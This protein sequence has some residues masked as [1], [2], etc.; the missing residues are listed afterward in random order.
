MDVTLVDRQGNWQP[1]GS[2]FDHFGP[3]SHI[4]GEDGLLA[5]GIITKEEYDNRHLLRRVMRQQGLLTLKSE[6]WHFSL[7]PVS[8]A[9]RELKA[10][11]L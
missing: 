11:E 2:D 9:R 7:M 6:W 8:R 1:M 3:E 10:V 4:D 5:E